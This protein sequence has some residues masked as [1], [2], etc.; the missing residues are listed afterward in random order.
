MKVRY[1]LVADGP[2]DAALKPILDWLLKVD[3]RVTEIDGQF[4]HPTMLPPA[5][6]GLIAR[7]KAARQGFPADI[8]FVHRDAEREPHAVRLREITQALNG[9]STIGDF[10][11]IIPVRMTEAWLLSDEAAI[12]RAADN[13]NGRMPLELP[14][15][16]DL[17]AI[18]D[19]KEELY[20]ALGT[21]CG[22]RGRQLSKFRAYERVARVADLTMDFS[23]LRQLNAFRHLEG[24]VQ[25]LLTK[26]ER[27]QLGPPLK[28]NY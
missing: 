10:V 24:C 21:A 12:R 22:L 9:N 16:H 15:I 14:R 23:P 25:S 20:R 8:M 28:P 27:V 17:E 11:P 19:P 13:P 1:T 18:V 26:F 5:R 3:P 7:T 2:S 4:A 6:A